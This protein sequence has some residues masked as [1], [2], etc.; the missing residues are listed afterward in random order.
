MDW[1]R[2][3]KAA[4]TKREEDFMLWREKSKRL[5]VMREVNMLTE[6]LYIVGHEGELYTPPEKG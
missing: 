5:T 6:M 1:R 4:R 2:V 3:W